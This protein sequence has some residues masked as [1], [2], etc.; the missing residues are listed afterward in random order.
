MKEAPVAGRQTTFNRSL[1]NGDGRLLVKGESLPQIR[2]KVAQSFRV[3]PFDFPFHFGNYLADTIGAGFEFV[4]AG[5]IS[6]RS[7]PEQLHGRGESVI[8]ETGL[9]GSEL[10]YMHMGRW[11]AG[12]GYQP[13]YAK[14]PYG[15]N[16][17]LIRMRAQVLLE[18]SEREAG[19]AKVKWIVWSKG[20]LTALAAIKQNP[21]KVCQLVDDIAFL[22]I[23]LECEV[24]AVVRQ[25]YMITQRLNKAIFGEDDFDFL[26]QL[27]FSDGIKIPEGVR[28]LVIDSVN[29]GVSTFANGQNPHTQFVRGTHSGLG[30]NFAVFCKIAESFAQAA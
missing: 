13:V 19:G 6:S 22:G 5:L 8:M 17:E 15:S 16:W 7:L 12:I 29:N 9:L 26:E 23:P 3:S 4:E 11:L 18:T 2:Q 24:N 25:I 21:E 10:F 28:F 27:E 20:T 1:E 14:H 30:F